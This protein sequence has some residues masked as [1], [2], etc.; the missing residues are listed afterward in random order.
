[1][2]VH[3]ECNTIAVG[4]QFPPTAISIVSS[5]GNVNAFTDLA[6]GSLSLPSADV[7]IPTR[8]PV[9]RSFPASLGTSRAIAVRLT[10]VI[11]ARVRRCDSPRPSPP[12]QWHSVTGASGGPLAT[13]RASHERIQPKARAE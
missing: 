3:V 7:K 9:A 13:A 8:D 12:L 1:M 11:A 4:C 10:N 2:D 6:V 5:L